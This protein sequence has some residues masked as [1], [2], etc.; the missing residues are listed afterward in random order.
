MD[1][2]M[3]VLSP[4]DGDMLTGR[5]GMTRDGRLYV[6]VRVSAP[7]GRKITV[8]GAEAAYCGGEYRAEAELGGYRNEITVADADRGAVQSL[9]VYRLK[10]FEGKY[11]LSLDDNIWFLRDIAANAG[12]YRSLFDN[13]Y[14]GFFRQVHETFGTKIH[15]NVYYQ[16]DGFDLTRMPDKYRGE[17]RD[18]A[19]WLRLSFHALADEPEKPY[20]RSGYDEMRGDC[21][22][23]MEQVRRF[24]GEELTGPVTT[25][26]WGEATD[27]GCRALRDCGFG[28]LVGDFNVDCDLPPVSYDLDVEKRRHINRRTVWKDERR[29]IVF[30]RS[31]IIVDCHSLAGIR[32]FLDGF[33][34]RPE[35]SA[36]VDL[37]IHEQ[38]FYPGY[39]A[40]Q[41]NYRQKV[42]E[43][44]KWA[45]DNGYAP[46]FLSE[47]VFD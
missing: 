46:A 13:P 37:L 29:D 16:T 32:P 12:R 40:Y 45:D 18:N 26:H 23:V 5:D 8:N 6:P 39:A 14:L 7:P 38:Y 24:A 22:K 15:I 3:T 41:P 31:A 10:R 47:C 35:R 19:G 43:A 9:A 20:M 25:L 27:G 28:C 42:L 11:R 17:W 44:V 2:A 1:A 34:A 30:F 36:F 4:L 21:E 33:K